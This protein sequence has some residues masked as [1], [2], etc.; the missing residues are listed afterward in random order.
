MAPPPPLDLDT[1]AVASAA[2]GVA[3]AA[4]AAT[5]VTLQVAVAASRERVVGAVVAASIPIGTTVGA[6]GT[7]PPTLRLVI[8]SSQPVRAPPL[9][10]P[11]VLSA[12]WL[13]QPPLVPP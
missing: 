9:A 7:R 10:P 4:L 12:P 11:W 3:P 5:I 6:T 13:L 2:A 8:P 1:I